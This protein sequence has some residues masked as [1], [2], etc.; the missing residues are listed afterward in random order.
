MRQ[1]GAV[2]AGIGLVVLAVIFAVGVGL[3]LL[4]MISLLPAVTLAE[5]RIADLLGRRREPGGGE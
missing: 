4:L 5:S 1:D 3:F 2:S